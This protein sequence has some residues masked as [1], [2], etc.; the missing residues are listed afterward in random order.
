[1]VVLSVVD[2]E[3]QG[4]FFT[5][6]ALCGCQYVCTQLFKYSVTHFPFLAKI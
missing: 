4:V 3:I 2:P 5:F 1:M 6:D